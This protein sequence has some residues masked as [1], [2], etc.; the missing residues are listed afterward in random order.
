MKRYNIIMVYDHEFKKILFCKR[1][2]RPYAGKLNFPGGKWETGETYV[3][4]AYRELQEETG[5]KKNEISS[6]FH[7][8]DF[9]YYDTN[10]ILELYVCKLLHDVEL[11]P[12]PDGNELV[13]VDIDRA[14]FSNS[15]IFGGDGNIL[16]CYLIAEHNRERI[17]PGEQE[18]LL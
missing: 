14:D 5:I 11:V 2:K 16:H 10:N 18:T 12:E 17:F 4:A 1:Q 15:E 7:L 6:L 13:W 3:D 8:I 9:I